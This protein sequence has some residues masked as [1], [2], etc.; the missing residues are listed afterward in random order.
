LKIRVK[1]HH[2]AI[3]NGRDAGLRGPSR[4]ERAATETADE[5]TDVG[6]EKANEFWCHVVAIALIIAVKTSVKSA[7]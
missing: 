4:I 6:A 1:C 3:A 2:S 5:L 7:T